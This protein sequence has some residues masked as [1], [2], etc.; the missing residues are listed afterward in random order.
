[1]LPNSLQ[2]K[3]TDELATICRS[4]LFRS[5]K[6]LN[7]VDA[8]HAV[9]AY[10]KKHLV[11]ASNNYL[12]LSFQPE[13]IAAGMRAFQHGSGS[14]GA[15]LTTGASAYLQELEKTLASFK[16][17]EAA[18]F[19]N[20]GYMANVGVISAL[21][22]KQ[23]IIFS[24]ELN[25]A[26]IIDGA[27]LSKARIIVYKH[28]DMQD[29]QNKLKEFAHTAANT[30]IISDGVFSMDGD[31][32]NLPELVF[33]SK[34]YQ[35]CLIVDDAHAVGVL[36]A[37]GSG[38]AEY[39]HLVGQ[40]PVQ[41]GTLSKALAGEG[42]YVAAN[43][44]IVDYLINKS[45]SFIFS[46]ACSPVN[47]ATTCASLCYLIE[48]LKILQQLQTNTTIMRNAL[49]ANGLSLIEGTTP[50][51]PI[52][53]GDAALA[54]QFSDKLYEQGIVITPIRPPTVE[55]GKSRLRLTVTAGH[56]PAELLE[57]AQIISTTYRSLINSL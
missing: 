29:L 52:L 21:A 10:G 19:Y 33:L 49:L 57:A 28:S 26:S 36:G 20:T 54:T 37:T 55:I 15:R 42:G 14:T 32:A 2:K 53:I 44:K 40:V 56:N 1:M 47:A 41:I 48:H 35:S 11:L 45:R 18:L 23:S 34:K 31:I 38:T 3:I 16:H 39:F 43:K 46:T 7:F 22:D 9:D 51:I 17:S 50:I 27:R 5:I 25:H 12:G 8:A 24:D 13:V 6:T 4:N 30:F